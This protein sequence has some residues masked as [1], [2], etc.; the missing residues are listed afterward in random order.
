[1]KD[2][3][4]R[5]LVVGIGKGGCNIVD[6]M[7]QTKVDIVEYVQIDTDIKNLKYG[8]ASKK[9]LLED[10][11]SQKTQ[12]DIKELLSNKIT[13]LFIIATLG[14]NI[15]SKIVPLVANF[16]KE[17]NIM[18]FGV[19]STPFNEEKKDIDL[20]S[21]SINEIDSLVSCLTIINNDSI[22]DISGYSINNLPFDLI[23]EQVRN[24]IF[25]FISIIVEP[26]VIVLN[27]EDI[28]EFINCS[29]KVYMSYGIGK[30][31][32]R[33]IE[34]I[35]NAKNAILNNGLVKAFSKAILTDITTKINSI[36][37]KESVKLEEY[38][39]INGNRIHIK[40]CVLNNTI[41]PRI[42]KLK[43]EEMIVLVIV[44]AE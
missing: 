44:C 4:L 24:V 3:D 22:V 1:M 19:V 9:I 2:V 25:S 13:F 16:A 28:K 6:Y 35:V 41:E 33:A 38:L 32:N 23:D 11:I 43:D 10:D 26:S 39:R 8:N 17:A 18:T 14:G 7:L 42:L 20:I 15:S 21:K 34:A 30:G 29:K 5:V 37:I 31:P 40:R 27:V 36:T 12:E